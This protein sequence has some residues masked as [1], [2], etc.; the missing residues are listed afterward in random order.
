MLEF[1]L[2]HEKLILFSAKAPQ[3][4]H[5]I[6]YFLT[7]IKKVRKSA[8]HVCTAFD[9]DVLSTLYSFILGKVGS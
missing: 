9:A 2:S 4:K 6:D 5:M 8:E 7:E 3:V 1:N